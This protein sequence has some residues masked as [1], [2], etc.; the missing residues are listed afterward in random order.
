MDLEECVQVRVCF[1]S[2]TVAEAVCTAECLK[3]LA[4]DTDV[5]GSVTD[6]LA[7]EQSH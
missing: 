5:L 1:D 6:C 4:E 2:G 7:N 3:S